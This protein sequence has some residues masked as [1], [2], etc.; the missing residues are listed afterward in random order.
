MKPE[1]TYV[2]PE[3]FKIVVALHIVKNLLLIPG[4]RTPLLLGI[5]G[6]KGEG[7][8]YQCE[9]VFTEMG[10]VPVRI[11]GGE[12]ESPR[13]GNPGE[14]I[15]RKYRYASNEIKREERLHVLFINDFDAGAGRWDEN[16][17][18]TVNTQ[19]VNAT[20]MNIADNPED[21]TDPDG[22]ETSRTFR[23]PIILTGNDFSVLYE[24]LVRDGRMVKLEWV[25]TTEE[26][27]EI[28]RGIFPESE[29][30][31]A[32]ID[33]LVRQFSKEPVDFFSGLKDN[34]YDRAIQDL[35]KKVG[36][37]SVVDYVRTRPVS[38]TR[39]VASL[40][41]LKKIGKKLQEEQV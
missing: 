33:E 5:H 39:P 40:V 15:R 28:V 27:I 17:Q 10:I 1:F 35:I 12:M 41:A 34:L 37:P 7:K 4:V 25:P 13:S 26:K 18:Y 19:I 32:D 24:P 8:T 2:V 16:T 31:N 6:P 14:N 9:I 29:L 20:L 11:S 23:I 21:V 3:R 22:L 38:F 36:V 30:S